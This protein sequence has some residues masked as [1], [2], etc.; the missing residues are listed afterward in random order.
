MR[1]LTVKYEGYCK[2]C[3]ELLEVGAAAMYE[4]SMGIF[5]VRCEPQGVEEIREYRQEKAEH[6]AE[7]L[8][9]RAGNL[10]AKVEAIHKQCEPY[11][12]WAYATQ[13]GHI[14]GRAQLIRK[15]EKGF[16]M[17]RESQALKEQAKNICKVRVA[18]D[19]E[20]R[21][22]KMRDANDTLIS[23]GSFVHDFCFGEGEVVG[24][25]KK[26]YRIKFKSGSIYA[27]DKSYVTN[28]ERMAA[29]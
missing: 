19:A 14:P 18:G 26:S 2:R 12:D 5:C 11:N 7:R 17:W 29:Q 10:D 21:R 25:C 15:K 20:T 4:R 24:V 9:N 16:E 3:G 6:K 8:L 1:Q 22:Q 28:I 13:P 27:R 23:K